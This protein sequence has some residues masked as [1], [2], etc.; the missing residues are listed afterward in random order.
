MRK[1]VM[2][3]INELENENSVLKM[4]VQ[5]LEKIKMNHRFGLKKISE[6]ED[7]EVSYEIAVLNNR[8]HKNREE[9]IKLYQE[10]PWFEEERF[11]LP[12]EEDI[13][14]TISVIGFINGTKIL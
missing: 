13:C 1:Y 14:R 4:K 6:K 12:N 10:R 9:L 11:D 2:N 5:E 3:K 8:I 7:L